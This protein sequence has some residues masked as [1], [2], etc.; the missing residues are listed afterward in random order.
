MPHP[1]L[2][3]LTPPPHQL[4]KQNLEHLEES[5]KEKLSSKAAQLTGS[6]AVMKKKLRD[7]F[8][9]EMHRECIEM[10]LAKEKFEKMKAESAM[11]YVQA[12]LGEGMMKIK[13]VMT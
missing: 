4:A 9:S 2:P 12:S 3:C 7:R 13:G 5:N 6:N 10:Q 1:T 11:G 8:G